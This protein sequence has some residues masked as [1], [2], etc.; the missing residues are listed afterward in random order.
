MA[1]DKP[2]TIKTAIAF[3]ER[4]KSEDEVLIKFKKKD[5]VTRLMRCTLDFKKVPKHKWPKDVN[6]GN[7]L[8]NIQGKQQIHVFDLDKQDWR[9]VPFEKT[10]WIQIDDK[11]FQI[12][13]ER[14]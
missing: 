11:R 3:L 14:K 10:E 2:D 6:L 13:P 12:Q 7:I 8:S 9:T 1:D 4:I 5:G